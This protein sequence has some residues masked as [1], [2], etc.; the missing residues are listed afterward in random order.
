MITVKADARSAV[1]T[2]DDLITSGSIGIP[3]RFVLSGEFDGL[4]V[5]AVFAGSGVS[6]DVALTGSLACVVPHEVVAQAGGYLKIGVYARNGD[7]TIAIPTVWAE[8]KRILQG[9]E[10]S[11]VDP[12]QPTPDWTAQVQQMA[13]DAYDM[14]EDVVARADR[15]EFDGDPGPQGPAGPQGIPGP[16]GERGPAGEQG[17]GVEVSVVDTGLV[18]TN[19]E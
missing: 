5:I 14:A 7:G 16:Q 11:G 13:T 10:P 1:Y 8:T 3:V 17:P 9:T 19:V 15:G 2:S 6:I 12:S 4:S 18:L